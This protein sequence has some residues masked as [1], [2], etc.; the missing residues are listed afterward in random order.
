M[1]IEADLGLDRHVS[2]VCKKCFFW[3]RKPKRVHRSLDI[4]S[5]KTLVHAFVTSRVDYCNSVVSSAPIEEGDG[6]V[7]ACSN[8]RLQNVS[9]QG[10]E[11]RAWSVSADA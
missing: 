4:E 8:C 11:I 6:Q 7:A 2:N 1:T 10:P 9:S 3:L 5:V